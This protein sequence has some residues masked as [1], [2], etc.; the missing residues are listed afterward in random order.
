[1]T[2]STSGTPPALRTPGLGVWRHTTDSNYALRFKSF[3][4]DAQNVFTGWTI[5]TGETTVDATGNTRSG[6]ATVE[7]YD[8]N[9]N[10]LVTLCAETVGTRFEL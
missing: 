1:M 10:L 9:G 7:V 5:V 3:N 8:T 2:D 4:F 6:P